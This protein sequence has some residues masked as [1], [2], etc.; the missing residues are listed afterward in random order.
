MC[1]QIIMEEQMLTPMLGSA[2]AQ[3]PAGCSRRHLGF[4]AALWSVA[5]M[6]TS[7][8]FMWWIISSVTPGKQKTTAHIKDDKDLMMQR[9]TS[10]H[11]TFPEV[12]A[13]TWTFQ[14][15]LSKHTEYISL[16]DLFVLWLLPVLD[17]LSAVEAIA[18]Q[19][20]VAVATDPDVVNL[21]FMQQHQSVGV[22]SWARWAVPHH[23]RSI[24]QHGKP[25]KHTNHTTFI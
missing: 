4:S 9:I 11:Q 25:Q 13:H 7:A 18:K 10:L 21:A 22:L 12:C 23:E 2:A 3:S 20:G 5:S 16:F 14:F 1:A 15:N 17:Y 19:V 8:V 6:S 24:L